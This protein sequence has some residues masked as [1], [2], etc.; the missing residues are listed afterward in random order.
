LHIK[1]VTNPT[2][3]I[4]RMVT[5]IEQVY[6][7]NGLRVHWV[8]KENLNL[9]A[10]NDLDVGT[11][12]ANTTNEQNTLFANRNNA[13]GT[14]LVIYFVRSTV[15]PLNGCASFPVGQPGSVVAQVASLWTLGHEVGHN[16]GLNHINDS[17]RLMTGNDTNKSECT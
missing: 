15:P 3:A 5:A 6:E 16:L 1:I 12:A 8:S 17:D 7:G 4:V 10:L 9:P 14:D 13:W 2:I 11:C